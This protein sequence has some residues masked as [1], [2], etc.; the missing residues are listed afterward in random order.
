MIPMKTFEIHQYLRTCPGRNWKPVGVEESVILT[1]LI[2]HVKKFHEMGEPRI[3]VKK[4][5]VGKGFQECDVAIFGNQS[6]W[7]WID[8]FPKSA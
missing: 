1:E 3:P 5:P 7:T 2:D 4:I 6:Y 8:R